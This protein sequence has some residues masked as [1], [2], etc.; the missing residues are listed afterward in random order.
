LISHDGVDDIVEPR[1][2]SSLRG[3]A[4]EELQRID[5]APS[6]GGVHPD[7]LAPGRGYLIR[8]AVPNQQA[9]IETPNLLYKGHFKMQARFGHGRSHRPAELEDDG[10][11]SFLQHI[12]GAAQRKYDGHQ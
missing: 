6:R 5:D 7:K 4:F 1:L 10:L 3:N 11:L 12:K 2:S 9:L 8:V